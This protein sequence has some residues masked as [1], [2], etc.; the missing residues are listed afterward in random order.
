MLPSPVR[1]P[2]TGAQKNPLGCIGNEGGSRP[3][4]H[5]QFGGAKECCIAYAH[6]FFDQAISLLIVVRARP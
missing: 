6:R 5:A 4:P 3:H 2:A 1:V